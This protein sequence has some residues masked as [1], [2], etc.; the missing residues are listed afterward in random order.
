MIIDIR[1]YSFHICITTV[2]YT[3]CTLRVTKL[4]YVLTCIQLYTSKQYGNWY[5]LVSIKVVTWNIS[6]TG[7]AFSGSGA[8][9]SIT[10]S[11]AWQSIESHMAADFKVQKDVEDIID[12]LRQRKSAFEAELAERN[13]VI[14][15]NKIDRRYL[16]YLQSKVEWMNL[17]ITN[18]TRSSHIN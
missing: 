17:T 11:G 12:G 3:T 5:I 15:P 4:L 9:P 14:N 2:S 16:M 10:R 1:I 18:D 8:Y 7:Q 13:T 6:K